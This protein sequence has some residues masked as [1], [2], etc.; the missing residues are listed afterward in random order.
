MGLSF[1][2]NGRFSGN[3]SLP[4]MIEEVKDIAETRKWPYN[5]FETEFDGEFIP[6]KVH[7]GKIY[8]ISFTPPE[9]ETV[10]ICFLSNGRMSCPVN[11]KFYGD[12]KDETEQEYLYMQSVKTQFAG[13]EIHKFL[14]ELFRYL[15]KQGYFETLNITDEGQYWETGDEKLLHKIFKRYTHLLDSFKF[16]V[17]TV[18]K[19]KGET[20]EDYFG[21][22]MGMIKN[23]DK[24]NGQ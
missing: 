16:A 1:H 23:K 11:L 18:P 10:S 12:S 4:D 5:I 17:D 15:Q 21:R 20:W 14:I 7:D 3:A 24:N 2:Y 8:G 9:C 13:E 6:G 22:L 19:D